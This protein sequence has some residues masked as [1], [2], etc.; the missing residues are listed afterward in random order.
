MADLEGQ[1]IKSCRVAEYE[2]APQGDAA[3][4]TVELVLANEAIVSFRCAP[5]GQSLKVGDV[6][7]NPADL[8]GYGQTVIRDDREICSILAPGAV[9]QSSVPLVDRDGLTVGVRLVTD[10]GDAVHIFNWGDDLFALR[11]L[12][13]VVKAELDSGF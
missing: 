1:V 8:G 2:H 11:E 13:G 7:I 3:L 5:D 4:Q 9:I 10:S 12:P 6:E